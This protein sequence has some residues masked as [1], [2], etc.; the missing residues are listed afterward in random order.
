MSAPK[1]EDT[2][3]SR[4]I[5]LFWWIVFIVPVIFLYVSTK[6]LLLVGILIILRIG[7]MFLP[8]FKQKPTAPTPEQKVSVPLLAPPQERIIITPNLLSPVKE[9]L[10]AEWYG[11][12]K[13]LRIYDHE[14]E[15][16]YLEAY[17]KLRGWD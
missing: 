8:W 6:S 16:K 11:L 17:R 1:P 15:D 4:W 7:M 3:P 14:K 5:A 2:K 12:L 13:M 10:K 9:E